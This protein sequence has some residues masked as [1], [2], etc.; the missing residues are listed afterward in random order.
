MNDVGDLD[1]DCLGG[2]P[3][4]ENEEKCSSRCKREDEH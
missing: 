4:E 2:K 3:I 1:N